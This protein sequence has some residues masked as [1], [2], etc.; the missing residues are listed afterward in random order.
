MGTSYKGVD[1]RS[2]SLVT[3]KLLRE[4]LLKDKA[5]VQRF[6]AEAKV[7]RELSHPS[8]V[9]LLGLVEIEGAKAC[10]TEYVEGFDLASFIARASRLSLKQAL[11]LL[12]TLCGAL[13]YAHERRLLHNDL[14]PTNVIVGKGGNLKLTGF[15]LGA[16]RV[17]QLGKADGYPSPEFLSGGAFDQRSDIYSLGALLFHAITGQ[18]PESQ[19]LAQNG[20]PPRLR[21]LVADAP[22]PLEQILGRCLAKDPDQRFANMNEVLAAAQAF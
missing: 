3:V 22:E 18:H 6:L 1:T 12:K 11:D 20:Q 8:L 15:G 19:E 4:D 14:K 2:Q 16:L 9:R 17:R 10:V 13:A 21:Q 7:A 5:V